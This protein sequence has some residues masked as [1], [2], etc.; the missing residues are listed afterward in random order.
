MSEGSEA[1]ENDASDE[2]GRPDRAPAKLA[3]TASTPLRA[4][5][6]PMIPLSSSAPRRR[7]PVAGS[8]RAP[9]LTSP[10]DISGRAPGTWPSRRARV[11]RLLSLVCQRKV[12]QHLLGHRNGP[13]R[14]HC[15]QRQLGHAD[16]AQGWDSASLK[17]RSAS[18][19]RPW[20]RRRS[21]RRTIPS[22]AKG[23]AHSAKK[24]PHHD[25]SNRL[26]RLVQAEARGRQHLPP[27]RAD[28]GMGCDGT[29]LIAG[30]HSLITARGPRG[31]M[32]RFGV[33][34]GIDRTRSPS[35]SAHHA[36]PT[37]PQQ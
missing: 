14:D 23:G 12:S 8:E 17:S 25:S 10:V 2:R 19:I 4:P 33:W 7:G 24:G 11:R 30:R 36:S 27:P 15:D 29:P 1:V 37:T 22:C 13:H 31:R 6:R 21:A 5:I 26:G 9:Q 18:S 3:R 28:R 20:R 32:R 34:G 16:R 35:P